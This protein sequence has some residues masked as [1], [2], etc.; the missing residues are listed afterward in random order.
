MKSDKMDIA[1]LLADES[2]INYCKGSSPEDVAFWENYIADNPDRLVLAGYAKEQFVQLFNALAEADKTEQVS[3]LKNRLNLMEP[4]T[5]V[6]MDGFE[7]KKSNNGFLLVLKITA[8]ASV[9]FI[10]FLFTTNYFNTGKNKGTKTFRAAYG[11][12]K[13]IQLP[14]GSDVTLN[15]GSKIEINENFGG[16]TRDVY[17]EGEAFFDVKHNAKQPFIVHTLAMDV[18]ALGTAFNVKAYLNEKIT[19]TSLLRGLV[20]VTLKESHNRTMLLY[21][22]QKI[23][24]EQPLAK[25][26]NTHSSKEHNGSSSNGTDSLLKKLII[27]DEG[28][29]KEVAWKENKL[30][31]EDELFGDIAILLE[32]WYGAKI[33]FKDDAIRNYR[34]TGMFEKEDLNT[35]LDLLKESR[36]F[37]FE[38]EP[39]ESLKVNLS[40]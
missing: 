5:V 27:N 18:K 10:A 3:R 39:G 34:F 29:I 6:K 13:N 9:L 35:V 24:W 25:T 21:P 30:I 15:A 11:E 7:K 20:E 8:I 32:R 40:K 4:A 36:S 31:F 2:F 19:E 38:I 16:T 14:D 33:E 22:N 1:D 17:L 28:E 23:K 12:R 26:V 37:N